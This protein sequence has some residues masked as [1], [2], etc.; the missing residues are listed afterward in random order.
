MTDTPPLMDAYYALALQFKTICVNDCPTTEDA[1]ALMNDSINRMAA[2]ID[3]A[4]NWIGKGFKL[5]VMPEYFLTG[6]PLDDTIEGW[7][8]K[9]ALDM[10]GHEYER[11]GKIAQEYRIYISGNAYEQ[12]PHFPDTYFQTCF[13]IGPNGD[14]IYRYRRMISMYAPSP[15]DYLEKYLDIYGDDALFPVADTEIGKLA[16]I[17]SEEIVYPEVA[18]CFALKG[19]EVFCHS[20]SEVA[21]PLDT[22]KNIAKQARA[23]ENLAYVVSANSGGLHGN[24][25]GAQSTDCHSKIIN[26]KGVVQVESAGGESMNA[27][28]EIDLVALKRYRERDG[29]FNI[30][31]RQPIDLYVREYQ[32]TSI[33]PP[34]LLMNGDGTTKHPKRSYFMERQQGVI[35]TMRERGILRS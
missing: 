17:S 7:A 2:N 15:Y 5:V 27:Y 34:N 12:D 1:R 32:K 3:A 10:N 20:S 33:V 9:A 28:H 25:L 16:T 31:S 35:K 8:E 22:P 30:L 19:A 29:M 11:M 26:F 14:V 21:S 23:V 6:F 13:I 4:Q 18:R 24:P